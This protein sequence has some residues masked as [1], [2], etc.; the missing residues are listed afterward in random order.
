[1]ILPATTIR[2]LIFLFALH[3]FTRP[4]PSDRQ[5]IVTYHL[6]LLSSTSPLRLR[7]PFVL[8]LSPC[9]WGLSPVL[10]MTHS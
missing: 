7:R 9:P 4:S 2:T 8:P 1:M 10:Y 3:L 6:I 5:T